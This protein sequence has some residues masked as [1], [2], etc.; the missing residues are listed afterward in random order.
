MELKHAWCRRK[1]VCVPDDRDLVGRR[2]PAWLAL[3]YAVV[4][5]GRLRRDER[6]RLD[7]TTQA[8]VDED[9]RAR[10][11]PEER[12]ARS[13]RSRFGPRPD[14][15]EFRLPG[16]VAFLAIVL[17]ILATAKSPGPAHQTTTTGRASGQAAQNQPGGQGQPVQAPVTSGN[18]P[19]SDSA[20]GSQQPLTKRQ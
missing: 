9:T 19:A 2:R 14:V 15:S 5:A 8:M 20:R 18:E 4:R 10:E 17:M 12:A 3:V 6:A 11:V 7:Q 1:S 13:T 16:A